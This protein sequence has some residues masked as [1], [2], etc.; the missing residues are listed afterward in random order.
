MKHEA[1]LIVVENGIAE[2]I[3]RQQVA[4]KL[5]ALKRQRQGARQRLGERGLAH[6]WNVF[7]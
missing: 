1:L 5:D 2:N 3:G 7:N 4:C 6:A